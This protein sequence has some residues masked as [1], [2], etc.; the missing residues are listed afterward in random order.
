MFYVLYTILYRLYMLSTSP[1]NNNGFKEGIARSIS[2]TV[3]YN[4]DKRKTLIQ[5]YGKHIPQQIHK[6]MISD[7]LTSSFSA[8]FV[9]TTY[10]SIYNNLIHHSN[11]YLSLFAGTIASVITSITK[12]PIGNSMRIL[13]SGTCPNI[14]SAATSL[15]TKNGIKGLYKGY[16]LSL[17]E[18]IIEMDLR[19]RIYNNLS[20]LNKN[21]NLMIQSSIGACSG[22]IA[23]GITTPFDTIRARMI[24]CAAA[25]NNN[26]IFKQNISNLYQ[27]VLYR[28]TSNA[29]KS[30]A[31]FLFYEIVKN[32]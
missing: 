29:V 22:A 8:G 19:M 5:L 6:H 24:F 28:S 14:L 9:F 26:I 27:G 10:F 15:Y 17:V 31:F 4:I 18:D 21:N 23:S 1:K 7:L 30:A 3:V 11:Q 13:Q 2:Q 12:I 20:K 25:S 32:I 16:T